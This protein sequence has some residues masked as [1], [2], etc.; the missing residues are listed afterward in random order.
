M[1]NRRALREQIIPLLREGNFS[2][3]VALAGR[4]SGVAAQLMLF[5]YA[6]HDLLHWRAAEGL[7]YVAGAYPQQVQK[8]IT[9]LLYQLNEDSGSFGWGAAAALG[10][11]AR[12]RLSLMA[13][14]IPMFYG[15]L[16]QDFSRAA[17]LWGLGRLGE[18]HPELLEEI[19]PLI[20]SFLGHADPQVRGLSAWCL[21]KVRR[22]EAAGALATMQGDDS[23]VQIYDQGELRRTTV[24]K[25]AREALAALG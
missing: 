4:E 14:I 1:K 25:V 3:L 12:H 22:Q 6:P 8:L 23:P 24:G 7:G 20:L 5:L 2:G 17:M 10:E 19:V 13:E 9:R 21:G 18:V 16:E 11:I 15:L